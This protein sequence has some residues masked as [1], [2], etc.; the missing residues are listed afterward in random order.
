[1]WENAAQMQIVSFKRWQYAG[2]VWSHANNAQSLIHIW[3]QNW[4]STRHI[5]TIHYILVEHDIALLTPT[6]VACVPTSSGQKSADTTRH[7]LD[8]GL[9][10]SWPNCSPHLA[11][12]II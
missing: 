10:P 7:A 12:S 11:D 5:E 1:M 8:Q 2:R 4:R 3:Y 9:H 6:L